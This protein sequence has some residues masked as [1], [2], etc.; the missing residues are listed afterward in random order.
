MIR[1]IKIPTNDEIRQW[2]RRAGLISLITVATLVFLGQIGIS[3][4]MSPFNNGTLRM[5]AA[6]G[7]AIRAQ[8]ISQLAGR[9]AEEKRT[10][11]IYTL[12]SEIAAELDEFIEVHRGL[13]SF[14]ASLGFSGG[15]SN[16][17]NQVLFNSSNGLDR[18]A[19]EVV[20]DVQ[21]E[22]L[23]DTLKVSPEAAEALRDKIQYQLN[24]QINRL[25][26]QYAIESRAGLR[27]VQAAQLLLLGIVVLGLLIVGRLFYRQIESDVIAALNVGNSSDDGRVESFD[28]VTGFP[29]RPYL[30]NFVGE[31][32][33]LSR[34]Y[35]MRSAVL[36]LELGDLH[37]LKQK[38]G[39]EEINKILKMVARRFESVCR[40]GDLIARVGEYEF[41]I[42]LPALDNNNTLNDTTEALLT[43]LSMPFELGS[44]KFS[45]SAKVGITFMDANDR[46][47]DTVL[48][49]ASVALSV[50]QESNEFDIQFFSGGMAKQANQREKEF[51]ELEDALKA[52]QIKVHYQPMIDAQTGQLVGFEALV[53]WHH[54]SRGVLT[55]IH[56]IETAINRELINDVTRAVLGGVLQDLNAWDEQLYD[57]PCVAINLSSDQ[58]KD[59]AF[60]E[61]LAWIVDSYGYHPSRIAIEIAEKTFDTTDHVAVSKQIVHLRAK[62]FQVY[63]DDFGTSNVNV[64]KLADVSFDKVKIDRAFV[65]NINSDTNQQ[66]LARQMIHAAKSKKTV[67]VAEGVETPAERLTLQRLG[68]DAVQGFLI[69]EPMSTDLAT[70]WLEGNSDRIATEAEAS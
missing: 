45:V 25:I 23:G 21:S 33:E 41:V 61:E 54:E 11:R 31:L 59:E 16:G 12:R 6:S 67:V 5:Q 7:Q 38:V 70:R 24:P 36:N 19:R 29:N 43:K 30:R 34:E 37:A 66:T 63:L 55:P 47:P 32:C 20:D 48:N 3:Q 49:Q 53:R 10:G 17:V 46:V 1:D 8:N 62:G 9:L 27:G 15:A 40:N 56:F 51:H 14:D 68:V 26:D 22:F 28:P 58:L 52:E 57:V 39:G 69:S 35:D 60:S 64:L 13:A 4:L 44:E 42:V 2:F 18:F 65:S 50:A